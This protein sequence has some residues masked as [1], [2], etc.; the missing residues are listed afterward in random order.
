MFLMC[1]LTRQSFL[2][3]H[4]TKTV[5]NK[6]WVLVM[7]LR[8]TPSA[9]GCSSCSHLI[10]HVKHGGH[11][12]AA[13]LWSPNGCCGATGTAAFLLCSADPGLCAEF[14]K[15]SENILELLVQR[16]ELKQIPSVG[17]RG[18][19]RVAPTSKEG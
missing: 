16:Y 17:C 4:S 11:V 10:S 12:H 8:S 7:K 9:A 14:S 1:I 6:V 13:A 2:A 19:T 3:T 15:S 5:R 18:S